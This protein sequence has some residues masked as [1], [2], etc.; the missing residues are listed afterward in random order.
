VSDTE[1]E[2]SERVGEERQRQREYVKVLGS[3]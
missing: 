3:R 2:R 1:K